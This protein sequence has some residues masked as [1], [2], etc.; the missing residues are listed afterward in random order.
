MEEEGSKEIRN[1]HCPFDLRVG[2]Q[3]VETCL[4]IQEA[5]KLKDQGNAYIK[6][7]SFKNAE[8]AYTEAID[9]ITGA[10]GSP[11]KFISILFSNRGLARSK[12]GQINLAMADYYKA[13]AI[14]PSY[15]KANLRLLDLLIQHN[16]SEQAL[17]ILEEFKLN[18]KNDNNEI[19]ARKEKEIT[20]LSSRDRMIDY[21]KIMDLDKMCSKADIKKSYK[22]LALKC[23]PDKA[24]SGLGLVGKCSKVGYVILEHDEIEK[25][26]IKNADTL[27]R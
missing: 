4:R 25:R 18:M 11:I 17:Q 6:Q 27:F 16:C 23:H 15:E 14:D 20:R 10:S 9:I 8:S 2:I 21:Y 12:L 22:K 26:V 1:C 5:I 13:I 3:D 24:K 19:L 7:N